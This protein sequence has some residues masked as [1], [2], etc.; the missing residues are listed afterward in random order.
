MPK[1]NVPRRRLS[2][3]PSKEK[4][5]RRLPSLLLRKLPRRRPSKKL[6]LLQ[7]RPRKRLPRRQ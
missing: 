4:L 7:R 1:S 2:S 3:R 6:R 5:P